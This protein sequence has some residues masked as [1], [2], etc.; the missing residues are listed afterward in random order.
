VLAEAEGY[1]RRVPTLDPASDEATLRLGRVLAGR[2]RH[3]EAS[4][5]GSSHQEATFERLSAVL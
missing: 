1:F 4:P 5:L 2:G 3:V